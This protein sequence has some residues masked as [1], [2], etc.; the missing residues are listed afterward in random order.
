MNTAA[1]ELLDQE[2]AIHALNA[3]L[4]SELSSVATYRHALDR[5]GD[6]A[7]VQLGECLDSHRDRVRQLTRRVTVLGGLPAAD[8]GIWAAFAE[9]VVDA[10]ATLVRSS[11]IA[12]LAEREE[13]GLGQYHDRLEA[14]DPASRRFV[15]T[16]VMPQQNRTLEIMRTVVRAGGAEDGHLTTSSHG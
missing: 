10:A 9:L 12:V 1:A 13:H 15:E 6:R 4:R 3:L 2:H 8:A 16:E 5:L 7:P 11:A 14:L